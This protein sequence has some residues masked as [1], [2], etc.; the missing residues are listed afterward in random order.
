MEYKSKLGGSHAILNYCFNKFSPFIVVLGLLFSKFNL[1]NWEPY[2]IIG[3]ILFIDRFSFKVGYS[4]A[5]CE[6]RGIDPNDC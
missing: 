1:T 5:F 2:V 3:M 6:E 4:V